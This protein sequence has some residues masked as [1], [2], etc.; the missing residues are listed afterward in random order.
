MA[1]RADF[2]RW[3]TLGIFATTVLMLGQLAWVIREKDSRQR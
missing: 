1:L 2:I 3:L